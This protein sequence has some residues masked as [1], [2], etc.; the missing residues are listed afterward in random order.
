MGPGGGLGPREA[1]PLRGQGIHAPWC[2]VRGPPTPNFRA[3]QQ[4]LTPASTHQTGQLWQRLWRQQVRLLGTHKTLREEHSTGQCPSVPSLF[5]GFNSPA[6][7]P[8][9][10]APPRSPTPP[11]APAAPASGE[12]G[13]KVGAPISFLF[14]FSAVP[15]HTESPAQG[16]DPSHSCSNAGSL[17]HCAGLG[18]KPASQ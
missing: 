8:G 13:W 17:T 15:W 6:T 7:P 12:R 9:I 18:I 16:S 5:C 14:S 3:Q 4:P 10:P 2:V 1:R 11:R